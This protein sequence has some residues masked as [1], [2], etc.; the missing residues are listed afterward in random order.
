MDFES[1]LIGEVIDRLKEEIEDIGKVLISNKIVKLGGIYKSRE[2]VTTMAVDAVGNPYWRLLSL[3]NYEINDE[4]DFS[5]FQCEEF[6]DDGKKI[7][8]NRVDI[9]GHSKYG[10]DLVL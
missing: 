9:Y 4:L 5:Y 3:T 6:D 8:Q 10:N 7:G 2:G 1:K